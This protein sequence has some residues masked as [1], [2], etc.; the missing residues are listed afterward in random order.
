MKS[1]NTP[2]YLRVISLSFISAAII[3]TMIQLVGYSRQRSNYPLGMTI[4]GVSVSGVNPQTA[5]ER[6]LQVYSKPVEIH[7]SGAVIHI[8]PTLTGFEIDIESMLA[9]ADL[10]RTSGS[11]WGGFWDYLW[12][13]DPTPVTIPLRS[14]ISEERLRAYL[15]TEIATRYDHPA[16]P[17]Q[18]IPGSVNFSTGQPGQEL[19]IDRA[20]ILIEDALQSPT[21]RIVSLSF[22]TTKPPHPTIQNLQILMQQ[23]IN[24]SGFDGIIGIFLLDLQ[25]AQGIHFAL[26][27]GQNVSVQPDIAFT[28]S[29]TIKI[30]IMVS[31]LIKQGSSSLDEQISALIL[32]MVRKSGNPPADVLMRHLDELMG[33][34]IVTEDMKAIGLENTFIA[35]YFEPGSPLLANIRT[36]AN[37]RMDA[38]TD[39]DPYN[40][41][42]PSDIGMLLEDIYLCSQYGGGALVA[43][44]PNQ[45]NKDICQQMINF[46]VQDKFGSLIQAGVPDGTRV[47]HKHGFV[48]DQFGVTNNISDAAIVYT[49][50]GDFI[51]TIYAYHPIQTI[52]DK[53]NPLF[54][55]LTQIVYNFFNLPAQ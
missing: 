9:V 51:L 38:F 33:P 52:W 44:F 8:D 45:I 14:S 3:L 2:L 49:P 16:I 32:D 34:L 40:Q 5:S 1:Q 25:T 7:Y 6:V 12:N 35:G 23:T 42:T 36:P 50:G 15:H 13:R 48:P 37:Q 27:N 20:V 41:T 17:S 30:P 47:A 18:P 22:Q 54:V 29:S 43:R 11:F 55:Q 10:A 31:Y 46:L 4:A 19:N 24:L 28:A 21:N 26:N 53:V 39:P